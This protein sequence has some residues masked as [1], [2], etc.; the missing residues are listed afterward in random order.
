MSWH[1]QIVSYG[2]LTLILSNFT[3][4]TKA[5]GPSEGSGIVTITQDNQTQNNTPTPQQ[6][7]TPKVDLPTLRTG[8]DP[9]K[10][11]PL[12]LADAVTMVLEHNLGIKNDQDNIKLAQFDLEGAYGVFDPVVGGSLLYSR[13]NVPSANPFNVGVGS[14]SV[15]FQNLNFGVNATKLFNSG[16]TGDAT[17]STTRTSTN[18]NSS[19]LSPVYQPRFEM[20]FR[21]PILRNYKI[22]QSS[23]NIKSLKK[24]LDLAD[25]AFRQRLVDLI[26]RVQS[27]Y[28]DLAFSIKNAEIQRDSVELAAVQLQNNEIQVKAGTAAPIDIVSAQAEL[29][30]RKDAAIS[31]LV[32]ITQAENALK[33]LV[34]DDPLS[35]LMNYQII[36]TDII[37]VS[38]EKI[39]LNA[40]IG[41]AMDRRPELK[42]LQLQGELNDI[43]KE[44]FKNQLKPQVDIT[45]TFTAQGLAGQPATAIPGFPSLNGTEFDGGIGQSLV[46]LFKFRSYQGGIS[47]TFPYKNRAVQAS[48]GRTEVVARQ[49]DNQ[50]RQMVLTIMADVRNALQAVDSSLQ[51]VEAA[52]ASVKAAEEQYRGEKQKFEAGLSTTFFVLQRQNELSVARGNELRAKTDYNKARADLQRVMAN[53]LP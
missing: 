33:L 36:P 26:A 23:R 6:P 39:D 24:R 15:S 45:G 11:M 34:I 47:I 40:A 18:S 12:S 27:S 44:F 8:V 1:K 46:N 19:G 29:E 7:P 28:Y 38:G 32:P 35:D 25:V 20:T 31:A 50:K 43:D 53:N 41:I 13:N 21:Q 48:L 4:I 37:D 49:L 42:Q 16:A 52:R 17:F 5:Q 2:M 9:S 14:N 10:V 22:N 3:P 51:R 30:R